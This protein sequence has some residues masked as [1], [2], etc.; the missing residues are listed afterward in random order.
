MT[1]TIYQKPSPLVENRTSQLREREKVFSTNGNVLDSPDALCVHQIVEEYAK[2]RTDKIAASD[3]KEQVTY[4]ELNSQ[5]NQVA[6]HLQ[7][8]GSTPT[9]PVGIYMEQSVRALISML[10][11]LKTG[12]AYVPI[13]PRYPLSRVTTILEE[14]GISIVLTQKALGA[15]LTDTA[16]K[17]VSV[18][19]D[20]QTIAQEKPDNL[21]NEVTERDL[22]YI[23]FTSGTTGKPKGVEIEHRSLRNLIGWHQQ[24][25]HITDQ[26]KA[27]LFASIS[28]DASVWELWPYLCSGASLYVVPTRVQDSLAQL[29][30]WII[31]NEITICFLPTPLAEQM[32]KLEWPSTLALRTLLTG[33]DRLHIYPPSALP[34]ALVNNYGPTENTVVATSCVVAPDPEAKELPSIGKPISN[35]EIYILDE[36]LK[37]VPGGEAGELY[38][39]GTSLA[40]GYHKQPELTNQ[41]FLPHPF[42]SDPEARLYKTGDVA[43][44]NADGTLTFLGRN[45]QQVKIRGFRIELGE[46][47]A[48][49]GSYAD[50]RESCVITVPAGDEENLLV[51]FFVPEEQA[52]VSAD[53]LREHLKPVLPD[54]MIPARFVQLD[55][56]PLSASGK[57]DRQQLASLSVP[58]EE[59]KE[60]LVTTN[61]TEERL[62][63]IWQDILKGHQF[64]LEDD[65]FKIGGHSLSVLQLIVRIRGTFKVSITVR[66][67]F[68]APSITKLSTVIQEKQ[69][70]KEKR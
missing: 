41:R 2:K 5:A 63:E 34:F 26:D 51:A 33:G 30:S 50:L 31:D 20:W 64:T 56:L 21:K 55:K 35:V 11:V 37:P 44:W 4:R 6:R 25:F 14:A 7:G 9:Q 19:E 66:D 47:Q 23:I 16:Y 67:I 15:A 40:R 13:D 29:Q 59:Q 70:V 27:T 68:Q 48:R 52:Q 53:D 22:A 28:F 60:A 46:I 38:I 8:L 61:E 43:L 58:Q 39:A 57:V 1:K 10:G 12:S 62:V 42:S 18:D 69:L 17:L 49:L 3:E 45:D 65:F 54:Y 36:D 24:A 32:I